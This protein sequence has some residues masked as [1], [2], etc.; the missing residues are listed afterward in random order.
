M[1]VV[2]IVS[3]QNSSSSLVCGLSGVIVMRVK[4]HTVN[5]QGHGNIV[6]CNIITLLHCTTVLRMKDM[7]HD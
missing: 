4:A 3:H 5:I 2:V 6:R 7:T 1:P